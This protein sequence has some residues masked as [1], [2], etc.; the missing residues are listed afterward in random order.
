MA[1]VR[2][3]GLPWRRLCTAATNCHLSVRCW[4]RPGSRPL[5]C[6]LGRGELARPGPGSRESYVD[7]VA[8]WL[9]HQETVGGVQS[10]L[11]RWHPCVEPRRPRGPWSGGKGDWA[12]GEANDGSHRGP[13]LAAHVPAS[14]PY[15]DRRAEQRFDAAKLRWKGRRI[16]CWT[17]STSRRLEAFRPDIRD[18]DIDRHRVTGIL[19]RAD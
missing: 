19:R 11:E 2:G 8:R 14:T 7:A 6:K 10:F 1:K 13:S 3:R 15:G 12:R 16:F 18:F 4:S 9:Q 17:C 5:M